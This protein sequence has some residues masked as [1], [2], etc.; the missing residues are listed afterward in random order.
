[1]KP[2]F[3]VLYIAVV[4]TAC[5]N[6]EK[7]TTTAPDDAAHGSVNEGTTIVRGEFIFFE[8]AAVLTTNSEIYEV[9]QDVKMRELQ[10]RAQ[11][12]KKN[13][14][15]MVVATLK[16]AVVPNPKRVKSKDVWEKAIQIKDIMEVKAAASSETINIK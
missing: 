9:V 15:D 11:K 8:D 4:L 2:C 6:D 1:M 7:D 10:Q 3:L 16:V 13:E 12:F 14:I 5:K